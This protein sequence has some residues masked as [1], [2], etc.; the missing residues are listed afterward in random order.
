MAQ[1]AECF[2]VP[3][4]EISFTATR[5]VKTAFQEIRGSEAIATK[6]TTIVQTRVGHRPGRSEPQAVK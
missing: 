3:L 6:L 4:H 2:E 5:N 1:A